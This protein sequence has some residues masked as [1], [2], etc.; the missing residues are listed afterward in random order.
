[1]PRKKAEP[2]EDKKVIN[3]YERIPKK[4]L[5]SA[6][7]PNFDL[8]HMNIPCR[9]VLNAPS[10]SG[11]TNFL[12]NLLSL[13]CRGNGTFQHIWIITKNSDEPIYNWLKSIDEALVIKEGL[14]NLPPLDK[15]DKKVNN[16]V[17]LDDMQNEKDLSVVENYYI[18]CR[19][20]NCSIFFLSQNYFRVPKIIR[21]NCSYLII[22]KLSGDR[23]I[24]IILKENSIGMSKE[25]L[26][27]M[28]RYATQEK[29]SPLLIDCEN[30]D[31]TKKYRKGIFE[32]LNPADFL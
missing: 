26:L 16:L 29:F 19:K 11:K 28:Y 22:L 4:F 7:N 12:C 5:S 8:H 15:M 21:N 24:N 9:V 2:I 20:V 31:M 17:V 23:E 3:F 10:G 14:H 6:D 1:M 13:F 32:F 30:A 25:Q 27:N 18:R